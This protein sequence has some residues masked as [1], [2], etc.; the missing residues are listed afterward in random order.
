MS[1]RVFVTGATGYL[2][3]AVAIRLARAGCDVYGLTRNV[4][5]GA[6]LAGAGVRPVFGSLDDPASFLATLKNC[7]AAV[8]AAFDASGPAAHD[9]LALEAFR[10]SAQDGRLRRL[11]YTSGVWVH[12]PSNGRIFDETSPLAPLDLVRWRA[13]HEDI[14]L[15]LKE[16]DVLAVVLRPGTLYGE[17]RGILGALFAEARE[18]RT[19]TCP[20]DGTQ[21]WALVHRDDVADAYARALEQAK[22]GERWLLADGA[23]Q[24][25]RDIA[26]AIARVTGAEVRLWARE[27][28]IEKLGGYGEALLNDL[29]V[30]SARARRELGW[31]PQHPSFV[32]EA[33][34]LYRE[35]QARRGAPVA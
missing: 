3:S 7:D 13:A 21:H 2:G 29:Q 28:V 22:G 14:A 24:T 6:A 1:L 20:G 17:S 30:S 8:H 23:R 33:D 4:E 26:Q 18:K 16:H 11:L 32:D 10:V 35:W 34:A 27:N 25:A 15:D 5:R 31:V 12:G 19:V 9:Q